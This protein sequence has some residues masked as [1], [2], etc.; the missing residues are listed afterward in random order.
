M[1]LTIAC[2][3][4][5]QR[6]SVADKLR[7]KKAKCK[8]GTV[9]SIPAPEP[10]VTELELAPL[11]DDPLGLGS[12]S[13]NP[14]GASPLSGPLANRGTAPDYSRFIL[15]GGIAAG[16]VLLS[17]FAGIAISQFRN[18]SS[19]LASS[20]G[21]NSPN[22]I[23]GPSYVQPSGLAPL[24]P[25]GIPIPT[26]PELGEAK[27]LEDG[28]RVFVVDTR[29][30]ASNSG[31]VPGMAM[32]FR[33]YIPAGNHA[34]KSLPCVLVAPAGTNML[35]GKD[36]DDENYHAET[37]PYAKAGI[38]AV[39]YSLDGATSE[40]AIN[41]KF[42]PAYLAFKEAKSGVLN[43]RNAL[44][45]ALSKLPQVDP[46]RVFAAGHS[47]AGNVALLLTAHEPRI[48]GA[49]AYAPGCDLQMD[50]FE[51]AISWQARHLPGIRS[52]IADASPETYFDTYGRPMFL[53]HAKDDAVSS[54]MNTE[55]FARGVQPSGSKSEFVSVPTGGHYQPMIDVGIPQAI[56]WL[57]KVPPRRLLSAAPNP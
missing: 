42:K 34:E 3:G 51:L 22:G 49:I 24:D 43:G 11:N 56:S 25:T 54:C 20:T 36:I 7:G 53:F 32:R 38:I 16:A 40:T 39:H 31:N 12:L 57:K 18:S 26:F 45:F 52:F 4:C 41:A 44:E 27:K 28:T 48:C 14:L 55:S 46:S 15:I 2:S 6:F 10:A 37:L 9:L 50:Q 5:G 33:V 47:S 30:I 1:P 29:T 21:G 19:A 23:A 13:N 17:L 35:C 8:C